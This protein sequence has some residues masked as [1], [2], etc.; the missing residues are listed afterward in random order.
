MI[1]PTE[2]SSRAALCRQLAQREP[3]GRPES[4]LAGLADRVGAR[5]AGGSIAPALR[6]HVAYVYTALAI[7]V[8]FYFLSAPTQGLRSFLTTLIVAGMAAFGIHELRKQ[9]AEEYPDATYDDVFGHTR[10]KVVGVVKGA[11][12]GERVGEQA[13][14][15]RLPERRPGGET[16]AS[17]APTA[18]RR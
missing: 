18:V 5:R 8:C 15:L 3:N 2:L 1:T 12:I 10:D 9:T 16:A 4:P 11:N 13:S 7:I 14:K 17:E 6:Q